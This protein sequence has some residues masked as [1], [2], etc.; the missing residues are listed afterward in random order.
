MKRLEFAIA[1]LLTAVS[2]AAHLVFFFHAGPLWRDEISSLAL[3]TKPALSEFWAAL[4]FDPFPAGYFLLL[5]AWHAL[6]GDG[7][8]ALRA[9]GLVIGL[10]LLGSLWLASYHIDRSAPLW[11]LVLFAFSPLALEVGDSLRPYG[12]G[13]VWIVLTFAFIARITFGGATKLAI[14]G[15]FIAAVLSLQV[16]FTNAIILFAII[17]GAVLV[18]L[19]NRAWRKILIVVGIGAASAVSLLPYL[20]IMKAT[21]EWSKILANDNNFASVIAVAGDAI[22]SPGLFSE[23]IWVAIVIGAVV[24]VL[25]VFIRKPATEVPQR[26]RL[27]F[28]ATISFLAVAITIG[29]LCAAKYLVFP[30]YFLSVIAIGGLCVNIFWNGL[31]RQTAIRAIGLA[32]AVIVAITSL[33]PLFAQSEM[34]MSNADQIATTLEQRATSDDL[35]IVTSPLYGISFQRYYHGSAKW[36]TLPHVEDLTL[37]RWDLIK[38]RLAEPDPVPELISRAQNVLQAGHKIF[39]VGKLGPAAA[40]APEPVPPAPQSSFGWNMEAYTSQWKAELTYWLEHHALHGMNVPFDQNE[41]VSPLEQLGLFEISGLR[42][43]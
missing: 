2:I 17:S 15:A 27:L 24:A 38:R 3:A 13:L 20:P 21:S 35:I 12:L 29:F 18:L 6:F 19:K 41:S 40:T 37:H 8:V 36:I 5:R 14:I 31:S 33:R 1:I 32:L 16:N 28:A 11:P 39:L 22:A 30:R 26:D 7:D 25:A 43:L 34:R 4:K 9:L 42:E 10:A 23:W